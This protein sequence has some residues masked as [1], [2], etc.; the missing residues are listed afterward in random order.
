[1]QAQRSKT[2][3][4]ILKLLVRELAFC[5]CVS[6]LVGLPAAAQN[7]WQHNSSPDFW[8]NASEWSLG[9]VANGS[10]DI[11]IALGIVVGDTSFTNSHTFTLSSGATLNLDGST[12]ITNASTGTINNSGTIDVS[13]LP[14]TPFS[15]INSGTINNSGSL[16]LTIRNNG[17]TITNSAGSLLFGTGSYVAGGTLDETGGTLGEVSG[18]GIG[19]DGST[20][21]GALSIQGTFTANPGSVLVV[22]GTINNQGNIL[23]DGSGATSTQFNV[24]PSATLQGGGTVSMSGNAQ[25]TSIANGITLTNV[26]NT[27]QGSGVVG[28]TSGNIN[29]LLNLI[30]QGTINAN[31]S[32][33][34]LFLQQLNLTNTG[35]VEATGGGILETNGGPINNTGGSIVADGGSEVLL[36]GV[37]LPGGL[38]KGNVTGGTITA[39]PLGVVS[40]ENGVTIV[41]GTLQ[42]ISRT[43]PMVGTISGLLGV[44][45]SGQSAF[46]EGATPTGA[47]TIQGTYTNVAGG[48]TYLDGVLNNQGNI[49]LN[50]GTGVS[51]ASVL[52]LSGVAETLQGGGTVGMSGDAQI[53]STANGNTLT[54]VDNTIQ[55]AGLVGGSIT[56]FMNLVNQATINANVSGQ[57]L[58]LDNVNLTN[59]GVLEASGG[60]VL[61]TNGGPINNTGGNIVAT[62][63]GEVRLFGAGAPGA[64]TTG[65]VTGGTITAN[66]LATVSLENGVTIVGSTLD[67]VTVTTLHG[68]FSG[69]LGVLT[70]GNDA[71]LE[72]ATNAGAVTIQGTYTNVAGGTTYLDGV[73]NNQGNIALNGGT[74]FNSAV[75]NLAGFA[76]TLQGGGTVSMFGNAEIVSAST[77]SGVML[78]NV[79]NTIQGSGLIANNSGNINSFLNLINQGTINANLSGQ[80]LFLDDLNL[81][82]TGLVEATAG[83]I[84]E[85]NGGPI[86]NTGGSILATSGSVVHLEGV[87]TPGGLTKGNV[88]GGTITADP[89]GTVSLENGVTIVGGTLDAV[90]TTAMFT[91]SGTLGVLSSGQ[92]AF[93]EGATLAGPVT[94]QG[95]YIDVAGAVTEVD[96][97]LNNEGNVLLSGGGGADASLTMAGFADTL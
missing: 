23:L 54:N 30:N 32:G 52:N 92:T 72:G 10:T 25:I 6:L 27:I 78:T 91:V 16:D 48:T 39:K 45:N 46:L 94:I 18:G 19:L 28:N 95:T 69:V 62:S 74:A 5:C 65:S 51:N 29:S 34:L 86:N 17:G 61:E 56:S 76:E 26:D 80:P 68:T 55:G 84:L 47:V 9:S 57:T 70:S 97:T 22:S 4:R 35:T 79:D 41:G 15:L 3:R 20:S 81:T 13:S 83:G 42:T 8:S 7:N 73:L 96:G 44:L 40:L 64:L 53:V 75:L 93:L 24:S 90:Q 2:S 67:D 58:F 89:L 36:L 60:G 49:A 50:G 77:T 21:L 63:G 66:P 38:T 71:Y 87:N 12:A 1:V 43:I 14:T 11:N 88:T 59:T 31:V 37:G 85:T 82:N 33:Q